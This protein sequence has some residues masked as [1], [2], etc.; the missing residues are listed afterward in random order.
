MEGVLGWPRAVGLT[1]KP[2]CQF[3]MTQCVYLGHIVGNGLVEPEASKVK[4]VWSFLQ[5]ASKKQVR[6]FLGLSGYYWKFIQ[7]YATLAAPL[8]DLTRKCGHH[9]VG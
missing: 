6:G 2:K 4:A 5:P 3:G 7:G 1:I 8:T 9:S